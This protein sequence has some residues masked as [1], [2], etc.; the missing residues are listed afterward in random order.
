LTAANHALDSVEKA[1][2]FDTV[3]ALHAAADDGAVEHAERGKQGGGT[4]PL[5]VMRRGLAAPRLNR[6][7]GLGAIERLDLALFVDRQHHGVGRR[8]GSGADWGLPLRKLPNPK[9]R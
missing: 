6:Q 7:S 8:V 2:E 9:S 4:V 1:D 3:V 5:V